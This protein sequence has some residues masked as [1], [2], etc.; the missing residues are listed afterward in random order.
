MLLA[1]VGAGADFET[2]DL[3]FQ[4]ADDSVGGFVAD[5]DGNRDCHAAFATGA[6]GCAHQGADR[7]V[8]VGIGHD[9]RVILR[10]AQCLH[11]FAVVGAGRVDVLGDRRG[12]DE[13]DRLH[14]RVI[15]QRVDGFLVAIDQVEHAVREAGL[16]QE[17]STSI[18]AVGSFSD[19]F[20]TNVLPQAIAIGYI[21]IGTIAGKLNGVMP[22]TTPSG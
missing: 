19:G 12:A 14:A 6:K 17:A 3:L 16:L 4:L 21:H 20:S 2:G 11:A 13:A 1:V 10:A 7:V 15:E 8:D 5:A 9:D 22:A 18:G